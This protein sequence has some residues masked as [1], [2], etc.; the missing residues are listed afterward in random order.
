MKNKILNKQLFALLIFMAFTSLFVIL[1]SPLLL[2][3]GVQKMPSLTNN[4]FLQVSLCSIC[5]FVSGGILYYSCTKNGK[6]LIKFLITVV[7]AVLVSILGS[8]LNGG[9]AVLTYQIFENKGIET[10]KSIIGISAKVILLAVSPFLISFFWN[11]AVEKKISMKTTID[12]AKIG[13]QKYFQLLCVNIISFCIGSLITF[14]FSSSTSFA[15]KIIEVILFTLLGS[16]C[17]LLLQKI[18]LKEDAT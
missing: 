9:L 14:L 3:Y 10:V 2:D 13:I 18:C 7:I 17:F 12:N 6:T 16:V 11:E 8:L 1:D 5:M 15:I 4:Q